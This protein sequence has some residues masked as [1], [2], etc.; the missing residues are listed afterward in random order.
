MMRDAGAC[1]WDQTM[2]DSSSAVVVVA[3]LDEA[4]LKL[5][6]E[7]RVG[8]RFARAN[9]L[10]PDLLKADHVGSTFKAND[11]SHL[12]ACDP[13]CWLSRVCC[14][15]LSRGLRARLGLVLVLLL[16]L[17]AVLFTTI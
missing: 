15:M 1:S 6:L 13:V 4:K 10:K 8:T 14:V 16:L 5:K 7:R 2:A 17:A 11:S 3:I 12:T 9:Q